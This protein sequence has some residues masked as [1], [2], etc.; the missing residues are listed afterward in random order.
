M[1]GRIIALRSDII[2]SALVVMALAAGIAVGSMGRI[3]IVPNA[4]A[5]DDRQGAIIATIESQ[6]Q[7]FQRDDAAAA[8][9][10]A[11][12]NIQR[13]F[14][15]P[16]IFMSMVRQGYAAVYRPQQVTFLDL[17]SQGGRWVQRVLFVGP[18]GV[19]IVA[20]YFMIQD[21]SGIW[22]IDGVMFE[23]GSGVA[24]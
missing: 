10:H 11:S 12:P 23:E 19:P 1:I 14:P 9:T 2:T 21:A 20:S 3:D 5:Q 22:L 16:D 6:I 24:A 7:A 15:T 8:Y 18:N 4:V 17:T 13:I